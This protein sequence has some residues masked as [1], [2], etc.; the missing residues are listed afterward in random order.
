MIFNSIVIFYMVTYFS[1]SFC[2]SFPQVLSLEDINVRLRHIASNTYLNVVKNS[3]GTYLLSTKSK[4][5]LVDPDVDFSLYF[6]TSAE[7]GETKLGLIKH[8]E[9]GMYIGM[10]PNN[11]IQLSFGSFEEPLELNVADNRFFNIHK[12]DQFFAFS[13]L[14]GIDVRHNYYLAVDEDNTPFFKKV[15]RLSNNYPADIFFTIEVMEEN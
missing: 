6:F 15:P 3:E 8:Q 14:S 2:E 11:E 13:F 4:A 10:A 9:T 7:A 1:F 12:I 5:S